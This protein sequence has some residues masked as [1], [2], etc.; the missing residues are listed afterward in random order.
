MDL[1][2]N[3]VKQIEVA[4]TESGWGKKHL[5]PTDAFDQALRP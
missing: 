5:G 3:A 4:L 2:D 1:S